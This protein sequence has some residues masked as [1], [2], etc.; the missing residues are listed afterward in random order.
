MSNLA[1]IR[2]RFVPILRVTANQYQGR[3]PAG[4]PH[5]VDNVDG[6]MVG[7]ELDPNFALYITEDTD[8]LFAELYK[9]ESRID[10]RATASRQKY[11]GAPNSD[12][13]R[14]VDTLSDQE[15]RNLVAELKNAY[16]T[17]PGLIY[18]TDD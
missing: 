18:I 12:R 11:G 7:L 16:N 10:T 1:E 8:G 9:R 5:I 17:Q 4:Y 13:R 3:V 14:V 2:N 15:L 6:G